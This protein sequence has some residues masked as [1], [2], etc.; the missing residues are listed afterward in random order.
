[1]AFTYLRLFG[2]LLVFVSTAA[3][4]VVSTAAMVVAFFVGVVSVV[5]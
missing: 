3:I 5:C 1:M 2:C 4:A